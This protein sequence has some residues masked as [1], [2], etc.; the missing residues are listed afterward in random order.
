LLYIDIEIHTKKHIKRSKRREK[1]NP[2]K[3]EDIDSENTQKI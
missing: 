2:E 3:I 1:K